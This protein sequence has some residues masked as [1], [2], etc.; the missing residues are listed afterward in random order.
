M[1]RVRTEAW[2]LHRGGGNGDQ[3]APARL[4][5]EEFCFPPPDDDEALVEPLIGCWEANMGHAL[6]RRPVDICA[7]RDE[8]R[9]VIGNAGVVRVLRP[10]RNL[11][12]LREGDLCLVFCNGVWD[13]HGYPRKIFGYDAPGSV[14]LLAR[15]TK[16]H[17]RQLI[18]LPPGSRH[19]LA[20]WA[21]FSLR[22]ITAWANWK[23]AWG[24]WRLQAPGGS[25]PFV[26]G[27]GGGVTLAELQLARR[28]GC[29]TA[30]VASHEERLELIRS[31]GIHAVDRRRFPDLD[32]DPAAD[33]AE[34]ERYLVSERRFLAAAA[35]HTGG[36][37]V[38]I[39]I[40]YIGRPV[41]RAT[42][43]AL[44]RPAIVT[45]AGWKCGM[46]LSLVRALECMHWHTHVHTHYARYDEG[47]EAVQASESTG[48][49]PPPPRRVWEWEQIPALART[50]AAGEAAEMF[51][52]YRVNP[53]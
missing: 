31:A 7:Q 30:M 32:Y 15:R 8:P 50:Y 2:V 24:A 4:A 28:D 36:R 9:V 41:F 16:L 18:R 25:A 12:G 27:W 53:A 33:G 51:P 17:R 39:F 37:G 5:L 3:P 1:Q 21:A 22:F 20:Q 23:V 43:K 10:G 6:E 38:S 34:R 42:L 47:L 26:W 44:G 14:G 46:D 13:E 11:A 29:E 35:A 19:G 45:T 48:W 52:V 40:D 49:A